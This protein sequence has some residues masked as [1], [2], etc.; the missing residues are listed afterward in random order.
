MWSSWLSVHIFSWNNMAWLSLLR[1]LHVWVWCCTIRFCQE[2][3][4]F[5]E[6]LKAS[7]F[8]RHGDVARFLLWVQLKDKS[9]QH[10]LFKI[11]RQSNS[12]SQIKVQGPL[13]VGHSNYTRKMVRKKLRRENIIATTSGEPEPVCTVSILC[14]MPEDNGTL[15]HKDWHT[16]L[17]KWMPACCLLHKYQLNEPHSSSNLL[18]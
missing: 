9:K 14:L 11:L 18:S 6:P 8:C 5:P 7:L 13:Y 3:S 17:P 16:V 15:L 12:T 2:S 1:K 10:L 4:K